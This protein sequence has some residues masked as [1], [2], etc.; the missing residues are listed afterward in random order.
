MLTQTGEEEEGEEEEAV[1]TQTT[2]QWAFHNVAGLAEMLMEIILQGSGRMVERRMEVINPMDSGCSQEE[3][4]LIA[5]ECLTLLLSDSQLNLSVSSALGV[6]CS[7]IASRGKYDNVS[8][9]ADICIHWSCGVIRCL[10]SV[11][12]CM[13]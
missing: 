10:Y 2:A 13:Q 8:K 12:I 5:V 9:Y 6:Y 1:G 7:N 4:V 3:A 11:A